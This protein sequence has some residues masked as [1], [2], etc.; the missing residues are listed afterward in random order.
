[1]QSLF[2]F[3]ILSTTWIFS[4]QTLV[5]V[6]VKLWF[7]RLFLLS[8][9]CSWFLSR[10]FK[11]KI[12]FPPLILLA[13]LALLGLWMTLT[14]FLNPF[15]SVQGLFDQLLLLALVPFF[16]VFIQNEAQIL[17]L[18]RIWIL[19][20]IPVC[21]YYFLQKFDVDPLVWSNQELNP[22]GSTFGNRNYLVS[23]LI[24]TLPYG[25]YLLRQEFKWDR[26][27]GGVATALIL[28]CIAMSESRA[29]Q[30]ILIVIIPLLILWYT[31]QSRLCRIHRV[32]RLLSFSILGTLLVL[33]LF[34]VP[35]LLSQPRENLIEFSHAR[36]F[37][38]ESAIA[39]IQQSP[40]Y[41]HGVGAFPALIGIFRTQDMGIYFGFQEMASNAHNVALELLV[42]IGMVG[43]ALF[44]IATLWLLLR[45][46][47][48]PIQIVSLISM[49]GVFI[50]SLI[51]EI[52]NIT[53]CT[54]FSWLTLSLYTWYTGDRK[55]IIHFHFPK[56]KLAVMA[57]TI[58]IAIAFLAVSGKQFLITRSN[59]LTTSVLKTIPES[60]SQKAIPI[61]NQAVWLDSS[62]VQALYMLSWAYAH[63]GSLSKS[64]KLAELVVTRSPCYGNIRY[65]K[66]LHAIARNNLPLAIEELKHAVR[67]YPKE[68]APTLQLAKAYYQSQAFLEC[69]QTCEFL[70]L[71]KHR[72]KEVLALLKSA[73]EKIISGSGSYSE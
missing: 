7:V 66:G 19:A 12:E 38:W 64:E 56:S 25:M 73:E 26:V 36:L 10:L 48:N 52:A 58:L 71:R 42:E 18:L 23:Y 2:L 37:L 50:F 45:T 60:Q 13:P 32:L 68:Y 30:G 20:S 22:V 62:N 49:L 53:F 43:F 46:R 1:M 70:L 59:I 51:G 63:K 34:A 15:G 39:M 27:L 3:G 67:A 31:Q 6:D 14:T 4:F 16:H 55:R 57:I 11:R 21:L 8:V 61:L 5:A 33:F 41:G 44:F 54:L 72:T 35:F 40:I 28:L 29:V 47:L 17:R 24:T 9:F 69:K 65:L